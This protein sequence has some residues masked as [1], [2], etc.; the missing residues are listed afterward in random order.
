MKRN[1][2]DAIGTLI[3]GN[4]FPEKYSAGKTISYQ[5]FVEYVENLFAD[6]FNLT[7]DER[8]T[9]LKEIFSYRT[10][11]MDIPDLMLRGGDAIEIKTMHLKHYNF[12]PA[13]GNTLEFN[14]V[15]PH[16]KIF[17]NDP[18]ITYDCC[19][20]ERWTQ[21]D[22]IYVVGVL[23]RK[24]LTHLCMIY[25]MDYCASVKCYDELLSE[26]QNAVK[27]FRGVTFPDTR[28]LA[29]IKKIDPTGAT[30]IKVYGM[31]HISNP[32]SFFK[33]VYRPNPD[34]RF[35]FMCI[36]NEEKFSQLGNGGKVFAWAE[37]CP[38]LSIEPVRIKNPDNPAQK[39]NAWLIRYEV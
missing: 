17:F 3:K 38:N 27:I 18:F 9:H 8:H 23:K 16:Q 32:W 19:K 33:E 35:N 15:Y 36:I 22:I 14:T 24:E 2:I 7:T 25:G 5:N 13:S 21:K 28:E 39:R 12:D 34:A 4:Y 10:T 20:A 26:M 1:I 29:R 30:Y 37:I 31:W 6:S 11:E